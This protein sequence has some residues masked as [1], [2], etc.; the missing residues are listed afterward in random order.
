MKSEE[1]D[2]YFLLT[3]NS[4]LHQQS[5]MEP[6]HNISVAEPLALFKNEMKT[7]LTRQS[8]L[9]HNHLHLLRDDVVSYIIATKASKLWQL[10]LA[11][12]IRNLFFTKNQF[13]V[14]VEN[15]LCIIY[16]VCT[17]IFLAPLVTLHFFL[18]TIIYSAYVDNAMCIYLARVASICNLLYPRCILC[19]SLFMYLCVAN[20][21]NMLCPL[22]ILCSVIFIFLILIILN[23]LKCFLISELRNFFY[24]WLHSCNYVVCRHSD[25]HKKRFLYVV[26]SEFFSF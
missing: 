5:N 21:S 14:W 13:N 10:I 15:A 25:R 9:Q 23:S 1:V 6:D 22:N 24:E 3:Q 11:L 19:T 26:C 18:C 8:P 2:A 16:S 17:L 4:Y 7:W 20:L 12:S